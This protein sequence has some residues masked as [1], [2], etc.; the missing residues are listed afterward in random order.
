MIFNK[1]RLIIA[2]NLDH[3]TLRKR[4]L[5]TTT[6]GP[7][8]Q[9]RHSCAHEGAQWT[10]S[11]TRLI[12]LLPRHHKREGNIPATQG[13]ILFLAGSYDLAIIDLDAPQMNV[14]E[15]SSILK[16]QSPNIPITMATGFTGDKH[17]EEVD[18]NCVDA[19]IPKPF[20]LKKIEGTVRRLL[21]NGV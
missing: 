18:M 1:I 7:P 6:Y 3:N 17:W 19:I 13:G 12:T 5:S 8:R 2:S 9:N 15:L 11:T 20:K 16:E 4:K 21:N 10:I 14:W